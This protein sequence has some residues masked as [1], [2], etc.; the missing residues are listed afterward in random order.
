MDNDIYEGNKALIGDAIAMSLLKHKF[1]A[2]DAEQTKAL[3]LTD[4]QRQSLNDGDILTQRHVSANGGFLVAVFHRFDG[5]Y[6][7]GAC[8]LQES[9]KAFFERITLFNTNRHFLLV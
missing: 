6:Y 4:R 1:V 2:L 8:G 3:E 5:F 9:P 7:I